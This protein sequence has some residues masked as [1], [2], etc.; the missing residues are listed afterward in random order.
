MKR[1]GAALLL[2][3]AMALAVTTGATADAVGD[4]FGPSCSDIVVGGLSYNV[5]DP[6]TL[7]PTVNTVTSTVQYASTT[8]KNVHYVLVVTYTV[9]GQPKI[10]VQSVKGDGSSDRVSFQINNVHAD[11]NVCMSTYTAG[12]GQIY[13]SSPNSGACLELGP[14]QSGGGSGGTF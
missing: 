6:D 8:C 4:S 10:K 13:D 2:A 5:T 9:A 12:A 14:D 11:G 1:I 3:G 7:L